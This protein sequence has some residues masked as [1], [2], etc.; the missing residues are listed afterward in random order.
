MMNY[1]RGFL[2]SLSNNKEISSRQV[3][4][5]I[6]HL[7]LKKTEAFQKTELQENRGRQRKTTSENK[8]KFQDTKSDEENRVFLQ[9]M[10]EGELKIAI[11]NIRSLINPECLGCVKNEMRR[12][13]ISLMGLTEI[14]WKGRGDIEED[15]FRILY[16]RSE[17]SKRGVSLL[18]CKKAAKAVKEVEC[19]SDRM[20]VR[21]RAD[22]ID[23]NV[24]VVYMPT[25]AHDDEEVERI[26]EQ[27]ED[28]IKGLPNRKYTII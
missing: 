5:R 2:L 20:M 27:I 7:K 26:Y 19:I 11:W 9:K 14:R 25:S 10:H 4:R 3:C 13:N 15:R 18:L 22:P 21:L 8:N 16:S 17:E 1:S 23:L 6:F 28:K 12:H 24:V